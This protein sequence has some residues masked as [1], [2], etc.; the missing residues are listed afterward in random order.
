MNHRY[1]LELESVVTAGNV[2]NSDSRKLKTEEAVKGLALRKQQS[3]RTRIGFNNLLRYQRVLSRCSFGLMLENSK[4]GYQRFEQGPHVIEL[5]ARLLNFGVPIETGETG[6]AAEIIFSA[7]YDSIGGVKGYSPE[8]LPMI[9]GHW[10][11]LGGCGNSR[12]YLSSVARLTDADSVPTS[13][14]IAERTTARQFPSNTTPRS[15]RN[16]PL[17]A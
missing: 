16:R 5:T 4:I 10:Y 14:I 3:E 11:G 8:H 12:T 9:V 15:S 17:K 7:T 13:G 6:I 2:R 1:Y